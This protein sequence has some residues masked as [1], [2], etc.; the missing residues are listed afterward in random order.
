LVLEG[1]GYALACRYNFCHWV[2]CI[3]LGS[4][5]IRII[6]LA[7]QLTTS[8]DK[9]FDFQVLGCTFVYYYVRF[10]ALLWSL[11][12]GCKWLG[13]L[14]RVMDIGGRWLDVIL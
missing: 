13:K 10:M 9:R 6:D 12:G 14:S 7:A 4:W 1:L 11:G 2:L 5:Y 8:G 3:E